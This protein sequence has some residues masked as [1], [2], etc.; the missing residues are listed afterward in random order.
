MS[1]LIVE[2]KGQILKIIIDRPKANAIDAK[3]SLE[4]NR[5]FLD[6]EHCDQHRV[7]II[8]AAGDKYFCSGADLKELDDKQ[9]DVNYGPNGFCG[10]THFDSLNKPVI[11]AVNGLCVGGGFEMV[12]A[13]DL[14]VSSQHAQFFL[15]ETLI[16]NVP[17]LI[18]IQ[19]LLNQLPQN[20]A[21]E[22]LYT[23]RKV[24]AQQLA[25][26]GVVNAV[27]SAEQVQ[28]RAM[29]IAQQVIDGA[30]LAVS[31]C[32][33]ASSLVQSLSTR[34]MTELAKDQQL[35]FYHS[36]MSSEDAKEGARAFVEKRAPKWR[37]C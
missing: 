36:V 15:A 11:A 28:E 7:A 10:L 3:T 32:K 12:L 13:C 4:L 8:T 37:G 17:F 20:I 33:K 2:R 1:N 29:Q 35:D 26:F 34:Q 24:T 19:R 14:V 9:G 25:D 6:F 21:M 31:A 5:L 23:G 22:M 27:V 30:P 18:S 16:G